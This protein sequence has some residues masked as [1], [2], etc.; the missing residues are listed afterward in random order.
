[1]NEGEE[2]REGKRFEDGGLQAALVKRRRKGYRYKRLCTTLR[3]RN[4]Y[5][6]AKERGRKGRGEKGRA[7][8]KRGGGRRRSGKGLRG[9]GRRRSR[10]AEKALVIERTCDLLALAQ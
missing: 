3:S 4:R 7:R 9:R 2:G 6:R 5:I 8:G 10:V 1:M